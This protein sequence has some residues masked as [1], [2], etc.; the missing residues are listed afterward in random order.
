[1]RVAFVYLFEHIICQKP[2]C[3]A[4]HY[5]QPGMPDH[6]KRPCVL[7]LEADNKCQHD[8]AYDIINYCRTQYQRAYIALEPPELFQCFNGYAHTCRCHYRSD[9]HGFHKL[10]RTHSTEAVEKT[11]QKRSPDKRYKHAHTRHRKS[12]RACSYKLFQVSGKARFK[13]KHYNA[14]LGDKL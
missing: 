14:Y 3:K 13:H 10:F 1:M 5:K 8:Y 9:K 11:V 4:E 7:I 2:Y 6:I 12:L